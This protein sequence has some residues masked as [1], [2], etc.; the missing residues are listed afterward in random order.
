MT[1]T[2]NLKTLALSAVTLMIL[3]LMILW[4]AGVFQSKI[5]PETLP[6]DSA[7]SGTTLNVERITVPAFEEVTGTLQAKQAGDISAQIQARIKA[8][9]V[10]S[11]D[12]VKPGDL[13]ISLDDQTVAARTAQ[14]R[15]NINALD[16]RLAGASAHYRRTQQLY[17]KDSATRADLDAARSDYESL[18][19]Q[20]AAARSQLSEASHIQDFGRIRATFPAR[21]IDRHAE[22]G[23]VAYPGKKL[24][25]L[26]DP[27]ALRI[28][29]YIRESVAVGL[30]T[31]QM[32]EADIEALNQTVPTTIEEIVP[33]ANPDARNFLVKMRIDNR[34]GLYPGLFIRI[35]IPQG[36]E[37]ALA[38]PQS[39]V[40]KVGQL[41]VVWILKNGHIERRF[42]RLGRPLPN[43]QVR[44]ISGLADG[45]QLVP[46][47][48]ALLSLGHKS[49][50]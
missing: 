8:I 4:M 45:E 15:A 43:G 38:I 11:G 36:E 20:K 13:L 17:D 5:K 14:A 34:P 3:L 22:P 32:L 47:E 40:R 10:K 12:T 44:I 49:A 42:I 48:K 9:H 35:R 33:A 46:P 25:T 31:G 1:L 29:A 23:E 27:A 41:E 39:Y 16:A 28:E 2:N 19:S 6:G 37:Q 7:Y 50:K 30:Q 26:Y 18:K 21:V 24:L